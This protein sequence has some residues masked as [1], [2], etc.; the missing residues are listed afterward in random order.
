MKLISIEDLVEFNL[1]LTISA[2]KQ[3]GL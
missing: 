2:I 1:E 3:L